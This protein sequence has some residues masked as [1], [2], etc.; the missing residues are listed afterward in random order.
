MC[1]L[2]KKIIV[3]IYRYNHNVYFS[4]LTLFQIYGDGK[5]TRSFQYVSDLVDGLIK[6]MESNYTGPVNLGNPIEQTVE[7]KA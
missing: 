7:G 2:I 4:L 6:L 5:Q 1:L 3:Y